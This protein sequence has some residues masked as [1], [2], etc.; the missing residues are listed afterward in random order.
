MNHFPLPCLYSPFF[1]TPEEISITLQPTSQCVKNFL[2]HNSK[3]RRTKGK[4]LEWAIFL[5]F[6]SFN[7]Q[8]AIWKRTIANF[9]ET[10]WTNWLWIIL[11]QVRNVCCVNLCHTRRN[12]EILKPEMKLSN[13]YV[14]ECFKGAQFWTSTVLLFFLVYHRSK[15]ST[16]VRI[17]KHLKTWEKSWLKSWF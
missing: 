1:V 15:S 14:V 6:L 13:M 4:V 8:A 5:T 7:V 3:H 2:C 17:L 9:P 16:F 11:S 10:Q 12:F